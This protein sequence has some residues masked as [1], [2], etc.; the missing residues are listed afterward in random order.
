MNSKKLLELFN[1]KGFFYKIEEFTYRK[2]LDIKRIDIEIE[3]P[4]LIL[5]MMNPGS[6]HPIGTK[7]FIDIHKKFCNKI[8]PTI[9]DNTQYQIMRVMEKCNFHYARVLN[10]SDL[11]ESKSN[12][13]YAKIKN[14]KIKHS[15]FQDERESDFNDL[16]NT[17]A[18]QI[19]A[20]GVNNALKNLAESALK[21][22]SKNK[23]GWN[24]PN[25]EWT[26]YHPL[27]PNKHKQDEWLKN[28]VEQSN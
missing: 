1:V 14:L 26:Y 27:P 10:L 12:C 4:D 23:I 22:I 15:I 16:F 9:P 13:F 6:S 25:I 21:K 19:A 7:S 2:Y 3:K 8:V 18:K 11:C 28:I 5:I 24:K 17:N 20:W